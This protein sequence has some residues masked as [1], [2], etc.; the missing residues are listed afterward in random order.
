MGIVQGLQLVANRTESS[1][2]KIKGTQ[3]SAT[4]TVVVLNLKRLPRVREAR[5]GANRCDPCRG[6]HCRL[7][8]VFDSLFAA[9]PTSVGLRFAKKPPKGGTPTKKKRKSCL[10]LRL[11]FVGVPASAGLRFI[12]SPTRSEGVSIV[13][14]PAGDAA[15]SRGLSVS[16]TPVNEPFART[17]AGA[18]LPR[19]WRFRRK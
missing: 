7:H 14:T 19:S 16:D 9:V 4:P 11:L 8:P 12:P 6:Q 1:G 2:G 10:R 17:P 5:L 13:F 18:G 15:I 3:L